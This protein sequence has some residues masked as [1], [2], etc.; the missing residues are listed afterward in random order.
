MIAADLA[1]QLLGPLGRGRLERER[2]QPLLDL[3]LE[4]AGALDVGRDPRELQLG[5]VPAALEAAETGGLLDELAPLLGLASRGSPR[6][7]PG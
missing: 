1:A 4:V 2:P 6:R 5:T 3:G 7:G